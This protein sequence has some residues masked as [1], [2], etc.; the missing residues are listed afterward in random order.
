MKTIFVLFLIAI[1][2]LFYCYFKAVFLKQKI[3]KKIALTD[4]DN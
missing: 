2:K 1:L 3:R 4:G